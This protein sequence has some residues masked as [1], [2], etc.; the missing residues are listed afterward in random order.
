MT[1][2]SNSERLESVLSVLHERHSVKVVARRLGVHHED[3]RVW[4]GLYERYG[5]AGLS[6]KHGSYSGNFKLSVV[7]DMEKNHLSLLETAVKF[8][9]PT[10]SSV[11]KWAQ[12][13]QDE[14]A[15]G[16]YRDNRGKMTVKSQKPKPIRL[17]DEDQA[18]EVA[19]LRAQVA[20]LK[21]MRVLVEERIAR[22]SG[23]AP[24]PSKD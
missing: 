23:N 3:L 21:K 18:T 8:G 2:Y 14:G 4:V 24:K 12:I 19:R 11:R 22:E 1:K 5:E 20:Y 17:P 6:I 10:K 13:Y 7:L 9:I 15:E 16:L